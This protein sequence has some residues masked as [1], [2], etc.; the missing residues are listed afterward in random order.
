MLI[1]NLDPAKGHCNGTRYVITKMHD[2]VIDATIATGLHVGKQ[3]FIPRIPISPSDTTFPF[4]MQRRQFPI[5]PS[6]AMTANKAQGQTLSRIGIFLPKDFFAHGQLYV[7]MSRV[8]NKK[9]WESCVKMVI[10]ERTRKYTL[11][12]LFSMKSYPKWCTLYWHFSYLFTVYF[13]QIS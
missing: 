5:R 3:I 2:H 9:T 6:F 12:M 4:K 1:R 13:F 11:T 8:G 7:A 10:F